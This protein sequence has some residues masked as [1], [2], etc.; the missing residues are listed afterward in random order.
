MKGLPVLLISLPLFLFG[1]RVVGQDSSSRFS[2]VLSPALFIPVSVAAQVGVQYKITRRWSALA[3]AAF[4]TFYPNNTDYEKIS[5]WRTGVE[6]KYQRK[7][8]NFSNTYVSL[9]INYLFRKLVDRDQGFYYTKTQTFSYHNATIS[10]PVISSAI[11]I[12]AELALG[13]RTFIDAF[14]GGGSRAIFTRY[15]PEKTFV[16]STEPQKQD[17]LKFDNAWLF[18]YTLIRLHFTAGLRFGLRL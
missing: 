7:R 5:Y 17:F 1:Q 13:K 12:G 2:V 6:M 4:P 10:T 16:T 9:Q 8:A 14:I 18:N 3:E 15:S 11:K